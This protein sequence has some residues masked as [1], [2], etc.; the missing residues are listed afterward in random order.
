[1]WKYLDEPNFGVNDREGGI[2]VSKDGKNVSAI[3][4]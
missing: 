3:V 1:V 2:A 4:S